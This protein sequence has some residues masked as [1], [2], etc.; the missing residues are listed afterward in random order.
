MIDRTIINAWE[1][2]RI[3]RMVEKTGI[4][5]IMACKTTDVCPAFL[6]ISATWAGYDVYAVI[7]A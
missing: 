6:S 4:K 3:V 5:I 7:D 2:D 1:D